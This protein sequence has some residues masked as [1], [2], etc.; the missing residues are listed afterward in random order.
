MA[1]HWSLRANGVVLV[2]HEDTG[3]GS[4]LS[5]VRLTETNCEGNNWSLGTVVKQILNDGT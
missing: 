3:A 5:R 1:G 4:T 2:R